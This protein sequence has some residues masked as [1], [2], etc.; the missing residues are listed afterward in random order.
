MGTCR[1]DSFKTRSKRSP[2]QLGDR[3][4]GEGQ[5]GADFPVCAWA[6]WKACPT[7]GCL[8][9]VEFGTP[10]ALSGTKRLRHREIQSREA[11]YVQISADEWFRGFTM[12]ELCGRDSH[13]RLGGADFQRPEI[14]TADQQ[15][16]S[17]PVHPVNLVKA[18]SAGSLNADE[19]I[20][21]DKSDRN[22]TS[23]RRC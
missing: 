8:L 20:I 13:K 22:T 6:G 18:G 11:L 17:H 10:F 3:N 14:A 5:C 21:V 23:S 1:T 9:S 12:V 15:D 7:T 19:P 4:R 16:K 2:T